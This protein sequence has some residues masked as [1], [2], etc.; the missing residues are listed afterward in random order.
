M[1]IPVEKQ[2]LQQIKNRNLAAYARRYVDIYEDFVR[3]IGQAGL[4]FSQQDERPAARERIQALT[5]QGVQVR[6]DDK[7]LYVNRIS[8]ACEACQTGLGCATFFISL[9]CHRSCYYCFNPNQDG[10]SEDVERARDIT[11]ELQEIHARKLKIKH[12]ALTG[13]EPLLHKE[14]AVRFFDFAN[15]NFPQA[16]KRLYT[17]GDHLTPQILSELKDAGVEEIRLSIR[18]HD[19]EKGHRHTFERLALA[20][21]YI[22]AAMVEMPVLPGTLEAMKEVLLELERLDIFGINLLEFCFPMQNAEEYRRRGFQL[23][24][25]PYRTLYDYWYAGGLPVAGSELVC[26]DLLAF[27]LEQGLKIGVHYCSV[28]NKHTGQIYQQNFHQPLSGT[29]FFSQKDYLIKTAKVFGTDQDKVLRAF[30]RLGFSQYSINRRFNYLEFP[31]S[32]IPSLKN[33]AVEIGISSSVFENREGERYLRE[34]K[35]DLTTPQR[36]DLAYD[37]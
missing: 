13:G 22:P 5:A 17:S 23:K 9:Q 16:Y 10:Y 30:R 34:L 6:N 8:P 37:L 29:A 7:S 11:A 15:R 35:L 12:L 21:E 2:T 33:L 20:R 24:Y 19:L 36:F 4:E 27:T 31:V 28:E 14:E 1:I 3:R 26:L 25:P 32:A 18:M